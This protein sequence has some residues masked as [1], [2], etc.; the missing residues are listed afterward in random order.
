M[1]GRRPQECESLGRMGFSRFEFKTIGKRN[2][3]NNANQLTFYCANK[4]VR[5]DYLAELNVSENGFL[6]DFVFFH[7][8]LPLHSASPVSFTIPARGTQNIL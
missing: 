2:C 1:N 8:R 6:R 5:L 3:E 7:S 4:F